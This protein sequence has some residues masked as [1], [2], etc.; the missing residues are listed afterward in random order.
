MYVIIYNIYIYMYVIYIYVTYIYICMYVMYVYIHVICICI[1]IYILYML[2][3]YL[4]KSWPKN[5]LA[6]VISF[7]NDGLILPNVKDK[8]VY[9]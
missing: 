6:G 7:V 2:Y 5:I 8:E 9:R 1:Y 3:T 4:G